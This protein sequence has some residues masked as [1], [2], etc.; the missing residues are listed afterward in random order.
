MK[1]SGLAGLAAKPFQSRATVAIESPQARFAVELYCYRIRKF[2]GSYLAVLG[3]C[4]G[5]AFGGGV[6]EH[7]AGVR[8][9]ALQ[10][11]EW[12]GIQI[13]SL[14]NN[15]A[16]GGHALI[17]AVESRIECTSSWWTRNR[18]SLA[19]DRSS[20]ASCSTSVG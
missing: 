9:R 8:S 3:G 2:I 16:D 12:A 5:I 13:D 19:A 14:L 7:V 17:S 10:G 1:H 6:G 20:G 18:R 15:L 11:L 4:D